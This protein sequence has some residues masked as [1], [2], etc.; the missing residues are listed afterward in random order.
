MLSDRDGARP[1]R[2][3]GEIA[4][5][6]RAP[7]QDVLSCHGRRSSP[8]VKNLHGRPPSW[9]STSTALIVIVTQEPRR[10]SRSSK[11]CSA[12][13]EIAIGCRRCRRRYYEAPL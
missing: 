9:C 8:A 12:T 10:R 6:V 4:A 11:T 1:S 13:A 7:A 3:N 5:V 2:S